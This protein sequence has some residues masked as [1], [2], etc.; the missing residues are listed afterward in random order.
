MMR[1]GLIPLCRRLT[2]MT[3]TG[4]HR[5]RRLCMRTLQEELHLCLRRHTQELHPRRLPLTHTQ[6][7]HLQRRRRKRSLGRH[8]LLHHHITSSHAHRLQRRRPMATRPGQC[9]PLRRHTTSPEPFHLHPLSP[10]TNPSLERR[11]ISILE[12]LRLRLRHPLTVMLPVKILRRPSTRLQAR[13]AITRMRPL[14]TDTSPAQPSEGR[15]PTLPTSH[16]TLSFLVMALLRP[17]TH[18]MFLHI[19]LETGLRLPTTPARRLPLA[20]MLPRLAAT[21]CR[22][23][24]LRRRFRPRLLEAT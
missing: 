12:T 22:R 15:D 13:L 7:P 8:L 17:T 10:P 6:E 24:E 20:T 11:K 16:S 19:F 3:L 9:L 4:P 1:I 21:R 18:A 5:P 2:L 23:P 14:I